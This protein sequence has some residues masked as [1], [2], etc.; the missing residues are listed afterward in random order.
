MLLLEGVLNDARSAAK[1]SR[2][3]ARLMKSDLRTLVSGNSVTRSC[4]AGLSARRSGPATLLLRGR[5]ASSL[6]LVLASLATLTFPLRAGWTFDWGRRT[7]Q[8][9]Q[10]AG[11]YI[12]TPFPITES[13]TGYTITNDEGVTTY[14]LGTRYFVDGARPD[15][16]GTG[17]SLATAKRTLG[18]ALNAAGSGNKTI[19]VRGA[20]D[21][22]NGTYSYSADLALGG[23]R[24]VDNDHR[25]MIVG[26]GQE[27]PVIDG[28]G[29][30]IATALVTLTGSV[31]Q[32]FTLQRFKVQNSRGRGIFGRN[33]R[34]NL[35]DLE[36]FGCVSD[37]SN[38]A[39]AGVAFY[40]PGQHNWIYHCWSHRSYA[41]GYKFCQSGNSDAPPSYNTIEWSIAQENGWWVGF[42]RTSY[43][44]HHAVGIDI[45]N[46]ALASTNNTVRY[47]VVLDALFEGIGVRRARGVSLHHNEVHHCV[48]GAQEWGANFFANGNAAALSV[49]SGSS[50]AFVNNDG[51]VFGNVVHDITYGG[52]AGTIDAIRCFGQSSGSTLN[53]YN[54]LVYGADDGYVYPFRLTSMRG[55]VNVWNN[56]IYGVRSGALFSADS[57]ITFQNNLLYQAGSG[58]CFSLTAGSTYDHNLYYYPKGSRGN[59]GL[60]AGDVD[61]RDPR[62]VQIP[63][64]A[65]EW[66]MGNLQSGSPAIGAGRNVPYI[67]TDFNGTP[68]MI[69][70][71]IGMHQHVPS[72]P[73]LPSSGARVLPE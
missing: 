6:L 25:F 36:V 49:Y 33:N 63:V 19:I 72:V 60:G 28:T 34:V 56:T 58:P 68:K 18:A 55:T 2:G 71:D 35:I 10:P 5:V 11:T 66:G 30:S 9:G 24:G 41:H 17:L 15:D 69:P 22:F 23:K 7:D 14:A 20:H 13:T 51:E 47:C 12:N 53:I 54:N 59:R 50:D 38:S 42:G 65:Y 44:N 39:D 37:P 67:T 40:S 16:S 31:D 61:N 48:R 70:S 21:G 4:A 46:D 43:Y 62:F 26:Y 1:A 8:H 73:P 29:A 57:D 52:N 27:R 45:P 32:W 3:L 64:G